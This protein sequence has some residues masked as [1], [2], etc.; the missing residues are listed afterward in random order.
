MRV[1][2]KFL[3]II[4]ILIGLII[5]F[6]AHCENKTE[7]VS[8]EGTLRNEKIEWGLKRAKNN[9]Q[10]VFDEKS[11]ELI[12]AYNGITIG[13]NDEKYV[14]LTFDLGFEA[15][16]TD[17]IL[18]TLK[19]NNVTAAFF[20]TGHY[21]NTSEELVKKMIENGNIVGNHTV[22]H[23]SM[24]SLNNDE[25]REEIMNLHTALYE[26]TGYE[27]NFIRPPK[28]EFSERNLELINSLGYTNVMWSFAYDDWDDKKQNREEYGKKKIIDNIH[29]GAVILLHATSK[30]N[31]NILDEVIK[32]IKNEGYEFR[33]LRDFK[34]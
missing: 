34:K 8:A 3:A 16:Y 6:V 12:E 11:R 22:N 13:N 18:N 32:E 7:E 27:M 14:Y 31:M 24:P 10:P 25:L 5:T 1:N 15:G 23:H 30:D 33:S 9:E 4:I 19:E 26:K 29:N 17:S 2:K 28:G 20:I 21:L